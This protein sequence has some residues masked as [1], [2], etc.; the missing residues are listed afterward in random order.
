MIKKNIA[1]SELYGEKKDFVK[2]STKDSAKDNTGDRLKSPLLGADHI[3]VLRVAIKGDHCPS[4]SSYVGTN[5][6]L[7]VPEQHSFQYYSS[8]SASF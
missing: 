2:R 6:T 8:T 7:S 1:W 3:A 4:A 5:P